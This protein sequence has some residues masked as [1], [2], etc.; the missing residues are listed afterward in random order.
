[1]QYALESFWKYQKWSKVIATKE[2][3]T[4]TIYQFYTSTRYDLRLTL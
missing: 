4:N 1:M 2:V 3:R